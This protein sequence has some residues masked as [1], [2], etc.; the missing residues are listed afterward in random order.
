MSKTSRVGNRAGR[1]WRTVAGRMESRARSGSSTRTGRQCRVQLTSGVNDRRP[2][3]Y[4]T[5]KQL[6]SS[7]APPRGSAD[8]PP[9]S[10]LRLSCDEDRLLQDATINVDRPAWSPDG[11][12]I[13]TIAQDPTNPSQFEGF[14]YTTAVPSSPLQANWIPRGLK[15]KP[16]RPG[17]DIL[18]ASWSPDGSRVALAANW[19]SS[20]PSF[21]S[22]FFAPWTGASF[23]QPKT[24][25][26][27]IPACTVAWRQDAVELAIR[28]SN[29][30][31]AGNPAIT[32]VNAD[33]PSDSHKLQPVNA[34][35][36]AWQYLDLSTALTCSAGTA[37]GSWRATTPFAV[38]CGRPSTGGCSA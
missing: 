11:T 35:N 9:R 8:C 26:P 15:L 38:T 31:Q 25:N 4:R 24:T 5:E 14:L 21:F 18:F 20:D 19:G 1:L 33:K 6:P 32:R 28:E 22:I 16:L 27:K 30:C 29:D 36:P 3:F 12:A 13:L 2:V 10:L 23:G 17:D 37:A 7:A 34:R